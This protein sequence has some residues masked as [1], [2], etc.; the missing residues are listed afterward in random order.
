MRVNVAY[1][2]IPFPRAGAVILNK[3]ISLVVVA[4]ALPFRAPTVSF[5]ELGAHWWI[6]VNL[7]AGGLLGAWAG[8]DW[9]TRVTSKH[10][11]RII[12]VLLVVIASVLSSR[13]IA[14]QSL[15]HSLIGFR[16]WP[17]SSLGTSS[18]WWPHCSASP[19]ANF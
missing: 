12:A 9:T 11:Y 2:P 19:V 8:A 1:Q 6:I 18:A 17:V 16:S 10:L 3:A 7:L 13:M 5:A 4:T 15:P 14:L